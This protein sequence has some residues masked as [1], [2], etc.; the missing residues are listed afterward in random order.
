MT[1]GPIYR[2]CDLTVER[3]SSS[4]SFKLSVRSLSI[5]TGEKVALVGP[6]GCGK[7]TLLDVMAFVSQ[8]TSLESLVFQP[9]ESD[10]FELAP[11]LLQAKGDQLGEI[12][13]LFIG[14]VLQTGGLL[15]FLTVWRNILIP[16]RLLGLSDE[17]EDLRE[18][19]DLL[20][21]SSHMEKLPSELSVGERQRV[22]IAR[23]LAHR[24]RVI[25]ADEPTAA[26]DPERSDAVMTHL[27]QLTELFG[28]SLIVATHDVERVNRF[29][30]RQLRHSF[31]TPTAA[32]Q[33][34][35]I[36]SD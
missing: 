22:A 21:I 8:P 18:T 28:T 17:D 32:S 3:R 4:N 16:R 6:S 10:H 23:A 7:S 14:Y 27:V 12:R 24:P 26:L 13:R 11:A 33:V 9:S 20:G 31:E 34:H 5:G 25:I 2:V 19:L 35:S 1:A 29:G 36:F 30:M 15:P